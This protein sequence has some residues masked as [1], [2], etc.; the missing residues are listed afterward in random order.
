VIVVG[1][2]LAVLFQNA[3]TARLSTNVANERAAYSRVPLVHLAF[4]MI[5]ENPVRGVGANNF[6]LRMEDYVTQDTRNEWLSTVHNKYLL[7]WSETGTPA[8]CAFLW[9]LVITFRRGWQCW[10]QSYDSLLAFLGL[11]LTAAV[12]GFSIHML[13]DAFNGYPDML[14]V[15]AALVAATYHTAMDSQVIRQAHSGKIMGVQ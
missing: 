12:L 10:L 13:V 1:A 8:F 3:I 9:F 11:G 4:R 5:E 15:L 7:V 6:V 2:L 14:W